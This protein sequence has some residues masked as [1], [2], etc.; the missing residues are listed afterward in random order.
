VDAEVDKLEETLR[1]AV[2]PTPK[3]AHHRTAL[4]PVQSLFFFAL[5]L[6]GVHHR[7]LTVYV[8]QSTPL[9]IIG[10]IHDLHAL[11]VGPAVKGVLDAEMAGLEQALKVGCVIQASRTYNI[12][13][14]ADGKLKTARALC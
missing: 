6:R 7:A 3:S 10:Q 2:R 1:A 13:F 5:A 8:G 4:G 11:H 12:L 9:A 14:G